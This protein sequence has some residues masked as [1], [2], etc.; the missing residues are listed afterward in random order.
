MFI[1][2]SHSAWSVFNTC[3]SFLYLPGTPTHPERPT[4]WGYIQLFHQNLVVGRQKLH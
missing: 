1:K 2:L 3:T 4:L